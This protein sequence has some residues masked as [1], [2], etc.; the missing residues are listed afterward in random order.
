MSNLS[1]GGGGLNM[2][3]IFVLRTPVKYQKIVSSCHLCLTQFSYPSFSFDSLIHMALQKW[4]GKKV[5][6]D[7]ISTITVFFDEEP[8][9]G[10]TPSEEDDDSSGFTTVLEE[11]GEETPPEVPVK[12]GV[13]QLKRTTE[14]RVELEDFGKF[15][16]QESTA[17]IETVIFHTSSRASTELMAA[18]SCNLSNIKRKLP[19]SLTGPVTTAKRSRRTSECGSPESRNLLTEV[20][21]KSLQSLQLDTD[22]TGISQVARDFL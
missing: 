22:L 15:C 11:D 4:S 7:N 6:A 10:E 12:S 5:K 18:D 16:S 13:P 20:S 1:R 9:P 8:R 19:S 17:Y 3:T 21:S 14:I 2:R